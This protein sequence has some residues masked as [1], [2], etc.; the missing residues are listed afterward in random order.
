MFLFFF[1]VYVLCCIFSLFSAQGVTNN[2]NQWTCEFSNGIF[3]LF[4][5]L[6]VLLLYA[7][8]KF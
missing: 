2:K 3:V 8:G 7:K 5:S 6:E 4:L 1:C